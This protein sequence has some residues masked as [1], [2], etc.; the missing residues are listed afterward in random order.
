MWHLHPLKRFINIDK[1]RAWRDDSIMTALPEDKFSSQH[2]CGDSSL[3]YTH[4]HTHII[5]NKTNLFK[6]SCTLPLKLNLVFIYFWDRYSLCCLWFHYVDWA[7]L[8]FKETHLPLPP[9]CCNYGLRVLRLNP[10]T[11]TTSQWHFL[12]KL[13]THEMTDG[14][15]PQSPVY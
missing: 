15:M 6:K 1:S 3:T 14:F 4:Q 13:K 12:C 11:T 8:K 2:P 10:C 5:K 9:K 7:A